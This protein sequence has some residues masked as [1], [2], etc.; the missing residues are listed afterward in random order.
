MSLPQLTS[1]DVTTHESTR[2][3]RLKWVIVVDE[4][5][6]AGRVTNAAACMAAAVGKALPD[7]LGRDGEDASGVAH[8]GLPW[9]GCTVL[10]ADAATLRQ[11][12][13]KAATKDQLLIVDMPEQ[14]QTS[15][16]YDEYLGLIAEAES[17][18][19]DYLAVSLVGPRNTVDRLVGRL[20]LLR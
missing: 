12:R 6:P 16:V 18:T 4:N 1:E 19:L 14:A 7:L 8:P 2:K 3:A 20:A 13:T 11:I 10:A 5:L 17:D 15:R 9:A